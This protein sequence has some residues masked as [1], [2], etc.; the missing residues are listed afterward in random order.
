[1]RL[2][3]LQNQS[4]PE[5]IAEGSSNLEFGN[6]AIVSFMAES[7]FRRM[8]R[9]ERKRSE[10]SRKHLLLM[11]IDDRATNHQRVY[12]SLLSRLGT[13]LG[14][15][16]RDTDL[17]GWYETS[18]IVGV[19]FTELGPTDVREAIRIIRSKVMRAL[20]QE[21]KQIGRAHV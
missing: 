7:Q 5:E 4:H 20:E 12:D 16:I 15:T 3:P 18:S 17:A 14:R 6:G 1:M 8:V 11:L 19:I 21:F 9:R 13:L 2:E 10:R